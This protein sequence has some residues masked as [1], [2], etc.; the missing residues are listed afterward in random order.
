M[1]QP[2]PVGEAAARRRLGQCG[3]Q[4]LVALQA[5][6]LLRQVVRAISDPAEDRGVGGVQLVGAVHAAG[7]DRVH[8]QLAVEQRADLHGRGVGAQYHAGVGR[9]LGARHEEGVGLTAGWVVRADVEGVEV[10]RLGLDLGALGDL[11]RMATKM[12][13]IRSE[14]VVSG[15][16]APPGTRSYGSVT[17]TASSTSTRWSRSASSSA[18]RAA[19]ALFTAPRAWPTSLPAAALACGGRAP[20]P[21]GWRG[22]A[23][24]SRRCGL[25]WPPRCAPGSRGGEG[26]ERLVP[27]ALDLFRFQ[28][29]DLYRVND[30]IRGISSRASDWLAQVPRRRLTQRS[31]GRPWDRKRQRPNLRGADGR[32][33]P[34][35]LSE[36]GA[37]TGN[38]RNSAPP[39]GARPT[40]MVP[41]WAST[42]PLTM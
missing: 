7:T 28:G 2:L 10:E 13:S 9:P 34:R 1:G 31:E 18:W 35:A 27:H 38:V 5:D 32:M 11:E 39:P 22:P 8:R 24:R 40:V 42:M 41:P 17:S 37:L 20:T 12:S 23:G 16:R 30:S 4:V 26:G 33:R 21:C 14:S 19:R 36:A 6:D 25:P 29:L 3:G 15:W